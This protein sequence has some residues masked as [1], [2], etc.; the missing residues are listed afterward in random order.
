MSKLR[1][2]FAK[3][4]GVV[5]ASGDVAY[6]AGDIKNTWSGK[7][8]ER[9]NSGNRYD[10]LIVKSLAPRKNIG[11][12]P[13]GDDV[14]VV[15]IKSSGRVYSDIASDVVWC[16]DSDDSDIDTWQPDI[17]ALVKMQD[18]HDKKALAD[19]KP[20][21]KTVVDAV[22]HYR[23]QNSWDHIIF[24]DDKW[25]CCDFGEWMKFS[26]CTKKEFNQCVNEMSLNKYGQI[27][28]DIYSIHTK[29]LLTKE[30]RDYS[31]YEKAKSP[32]QII[33]LPKPKPQ[34]KT[35]YE[36]CVEGFLEVA[37]EHSEGCLYSH[38]SGGYSEI[39]GLESLIGNYDHANVYRKVE[40]EYTWQE[41]AAE[42]IANSKVLE[43]TDDF[44]LIGSS[45]EW[46][47]DFAGLCSIVHNAK[48]GE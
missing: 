39:E 36:K 1:V 25:G 2:S 31:F 30:N 19:L 37:R 16:I 15:C 10:D 20:E 23:G 9:A 44:S 12:Q 18:E 32:K 35:E 34:I 38:H 40:R 14:P 45:D 13:C 28:F 46:D 41:E 21:P 17:E 47:N 6:S 11:E 7:W 4:K 26:V 48:A 24:K 29:Q 42:F 33:E 43:L 5:F 22:N 27:E 8:W 3:E